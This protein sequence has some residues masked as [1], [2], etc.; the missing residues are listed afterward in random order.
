MPGPLFFFGAMSPYSWFAAERIDGLIDDVAWRPV[1]AGGLFRSVGRE[2]WG[3]TER[4][5]SGIADCEARALRH[6]LG[7][8]RWPDGWPASDVLVARAMVVADAWGALRP[9]ALAAMRAQFRDGARLDDP[10]VLAAIA[11]GARLDGRALL[12]DA[13]SEPVKRELRARTDDAVARG[14]TGVPTVVSG[15]RRWWG[16]DRLDAAAAAISG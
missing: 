2:S 15:D 11:T 14:V 9:F 7:P 3:L 8:M 13:A 6:G 16:D 4:R 12:A 1:F 5:Q 10:H